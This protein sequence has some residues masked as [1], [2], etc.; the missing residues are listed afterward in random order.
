MLISQEQKELL[1][2]NKKYFWSF[3]KGFK[4]LEIVS[5]PRV[6]FK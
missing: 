6:G 5:D 2:Q 3:L 4:L 1:T